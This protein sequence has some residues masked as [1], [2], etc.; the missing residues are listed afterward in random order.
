[1]PDSELSWSVDELYDDWFNSIRRA[2]E[3]DTEPIR[4]L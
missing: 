3:S 1:M 4:S 2:V